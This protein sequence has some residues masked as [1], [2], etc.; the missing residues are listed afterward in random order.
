M[1]EENENKEEKKEEETKKGKLM[2][3]PV[4]EIY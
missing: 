4:C 1:S 3:D 2:G